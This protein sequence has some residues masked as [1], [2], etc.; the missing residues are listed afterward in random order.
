MTNSNRWYEEGEGGIL[1][2]EKVG[3]L[4][5]CQCSMCICTDKS[6]IPKI[7]KTSAGVLV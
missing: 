7:L 2:V 5:R 3:C 6:E 1:D 4:D